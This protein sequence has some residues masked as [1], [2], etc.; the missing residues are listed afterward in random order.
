MTRVLEFT[1]DEIARE[2]LLAAL[3]RI[4][5]LA[6]VQ[7][8]DPDKRALQLQQIHVTARDAI[9]KAKVQP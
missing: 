1:G 3:R 9:R 7:Y 5:E 6:D 2:N 8:A 4:V